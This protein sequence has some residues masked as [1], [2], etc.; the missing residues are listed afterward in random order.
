MFTPTTDFMSSHY[1]THIENF[2]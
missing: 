2:K 1:C